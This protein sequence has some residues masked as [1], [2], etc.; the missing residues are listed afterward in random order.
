MSENT[1]A[2]I[3]DFPETKVAAANVKQATSL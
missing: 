2:K 1:D 3:V